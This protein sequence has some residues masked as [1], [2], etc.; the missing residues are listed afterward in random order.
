MNNPVHVKL[1]TKDED[2]PVIVHNVRNKK[3]KSYIELKGLD[4]LSI[5]CV[6]TNGPTLC[7]IVWLP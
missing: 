7:P 6:R 5:N 3:F 2:L 1:K 4:Y